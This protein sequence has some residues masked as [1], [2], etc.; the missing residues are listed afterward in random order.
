MVIVI[1]SLTQH[2]DSHPIMA[3]LSISQSQASDMMSSHVMM[4]SPTLSQTNQLQAS[5]MMSSHTM[6]MSS[7][8]AMQ[9]TC[10]IYGS[11]KPHPIR[12]TGVLRGSTEELTT[13]EDGGKA[14]GHT[15][16]ELGSRQEVTT[17]A[18]GASQLATPQL[19]PLHMKY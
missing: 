10:L 8:N 16:W 14:K 7:Q 9:Q 5:E 13:R 19:L 18:S 15:L 6:M 11:S 2:K 17:E 4:V 12:Q 1:A 3:K